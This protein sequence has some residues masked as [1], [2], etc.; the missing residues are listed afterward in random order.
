M[1]YKRLHLS[2]DLCNKMQVKMS[3]S[4]Y[5]GWHHS[6]CRRPS[7]NAPQLLSPCPHLLEIVLSL[8]SIPD[9]TAET[10]T[11][12]RGEPRRAK[13]TNITRHFRVP[14]KN[15]KRSIS[16]LMTGHMFRWTVSLHKHV[17]LRSKCGLLF[18][19]YC[20]WEAYIT[21]QTILWQTYN[22]NVMIGTS[23]ST[24]TTC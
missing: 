2:F 13:S 14:R 5:R 23:I 12:E 15:R 21:V 3:R 18:F 20:C 4:L 17:R 11:E 19:Y 10:H 22:T 1:W 7:L 16:E 6:P 24:L 9:S 8:M